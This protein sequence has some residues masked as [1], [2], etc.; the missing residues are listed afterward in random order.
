LANHQWI[1]HTTQPRP[2][3]IADRTIAEARER[4]DIVRLIRAFTPLIAENEPP[5]TY[6]GPCHSMRTRPT[7]QHSTG[8]MLALPDQ[9]VVSNPLQIVRAW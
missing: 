8:F 9:V 1:A 7:Q 2:Q 3:G 5:T 4:R 6:L